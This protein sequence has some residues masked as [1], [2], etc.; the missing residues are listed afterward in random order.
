[1]SHVTILDFPEAR[2]ARQWENPEASTGTEPWYMYDAPAVASW[3]PLVPPGWRWTKMIRDLKK[4]S[5]EHMTV[6]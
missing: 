1:M 3:F 6:L 2:G 5:M 4:W